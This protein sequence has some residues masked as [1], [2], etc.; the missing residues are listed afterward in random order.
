M[1]F[2]LNNRA[3]IAAWAADIFGLPFE[4]R[5][6]GPHAFDC[7]GV[8]I[9]AQEKCGRRAKSYTDAYSDTSF[10]ARHDIDALIAAEKAQWKAVKHVD[11]GDVFECALAGKSVHVAVAC[12]GGRAL[13]VREKAGVVIEEITLDDGGRPRLG[14]YVIVGAYAPG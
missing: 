2:R 4:E 12:G 14:D 8:V 9:Y 11:I 10:K 1:D 7:W 6:R 3:P 13:H 5:A